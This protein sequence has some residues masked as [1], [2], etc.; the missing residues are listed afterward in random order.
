MNYLIM[1]MHLLFWW[2]GIDKKLNENRVKIFNPVAIVT[3][4]PLKKTYPATAQF[5]GRL[6]TGVKQ[7][8]TVTLFPQQKNRLLVVILL[9]HNCGRIF[10]INHNKIIRVTYECPNQEKDESNDYTNWKVSHD[11]LTKEIKMIAPET[12]VNHSFYVRQQAFWMITY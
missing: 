6:A 8:G 12:D 7:P 1:P 10:E 5:W 3:V 2:N 11:F 9:P 4:E